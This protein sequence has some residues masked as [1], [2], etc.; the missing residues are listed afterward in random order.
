M[1]VQ[2]P[3]LRQQQIAFFSLKKPIG[4]PIEKKDAQ[5][6]SHGNGTPKWT[7]GIINVFSYTSGCPANM[8]KFS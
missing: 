6:Q 2:Y 7:A 4:F 5:Y 3:E 1:Y 8:F